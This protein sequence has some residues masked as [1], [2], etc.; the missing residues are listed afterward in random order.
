MA[1]DL[2]T[3]NSLKTLNLHLYLILFV[4]FF[5]YVP[6][7]L[8]RYTRIPVVMIRDNQDHTFQRSFKGTVYK[9]RLKSSMNGRIFHK[10][11]ELKMRS[12]AFA[13]RD[14]WRGGR[15]ARNGKSLDIKRHMFKN[16]RH[17]EMEQRY[18]HQV[19]LQFG[20]TRCRNAC[21]IG[22]DVQNRH[23][24]QKVPDLNIFGKETMED[25]SC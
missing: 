11:R 17:I 15:V 8:Q 14:Q 20:K 22:P 9:V 19:L 4:Y 21:K 23:N 18:R 5:V 1:L 6:N 3:T 2:G 24:E 25:E 12:C 16:L 10:E 7:V 13:V